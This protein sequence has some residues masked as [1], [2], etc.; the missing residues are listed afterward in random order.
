MHNLSLF[1]S[2]NA[3]SHEGYFLRAKINFRKRDYKAAMDDIRLALDIHTKDSEYYILAGKI[4]L[5]LKSKRLAC[6]DFKR[7]A[8]M[9][10]PYGISLLND[11]CVK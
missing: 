8:D 2:Q 1:L 3:H 10:N 11:H 4:R 9:K 5:E 6:D 7:V